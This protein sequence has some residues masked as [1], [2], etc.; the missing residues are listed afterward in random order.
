MKHPTPRCHMFD[1]VTDEHTLNHLFETFSNPTKEE[2]EYLNY[3]D[4][5]WAKKPPTITRLDS[6]AIN[7]YPRTRPQKRKIDHIL[8][9]HPK[10]CRIMPDGSDWFHIVCNKCNHS[11]DLPL[12]NNCQYCYVKKTEHPTYPKWVEHK[13]K[14]KYFCQPFYADFNQWLDNGSP[15]VPA[16]DNKSNRK[17]LV[18]EM[19]KGNNTATLHQLLFKGGKIKYQ[20]NVDTQGTPL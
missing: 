9:N 14:G 16:V 7:R 10:W 12:K 19:N 5:Q 11:Q 13:R 15:E 17:L 18:E 6:H 4:K 1:N 20:I 3:I 8:A 2:L